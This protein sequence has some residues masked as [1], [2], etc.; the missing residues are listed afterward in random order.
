LKILIVDDSKAMRMVLKR[1][2]R[3]IGED[4][5]VME[6]ADGMQAMEIIKENPDFDYILCDW[7]MPNMNGFELLKKLKADGFNKK[8]GFVTSVATGDTKKRA[9]DAGA[10][11]CIGKPFTPDN[12]KEAMGLN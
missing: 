12:I 11:F 7:N 2:L 9:T 8:F 3:L 6:A 1:A 4:E 5:Q 10:D